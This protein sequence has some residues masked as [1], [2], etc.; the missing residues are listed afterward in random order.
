LR[1]GSL[2][3]GKSSAPGA[4]ESGRDERRVTMGN[5]RETRGYVRKVMGLYAAF[6]FTHPAKS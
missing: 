5:Y 1:K 2:P 3:E 6:K 4:S